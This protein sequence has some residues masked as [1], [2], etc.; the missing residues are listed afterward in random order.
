[1]GPPLGKNSAISP[2]IFIWFTFHFEQVHMCSSHLSLRVGQR[3]A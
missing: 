3:K 1:M 2:A